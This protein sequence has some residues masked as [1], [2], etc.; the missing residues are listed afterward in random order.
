M[1]ANLKFKG[2][3][4]GLTCIMAFASTTDRALAL[5]AEVAKKCNELLA[6]TYPPLVVGNPAAGRKGTVKERNEHYRK[7]IK[8]GSKI[9]EK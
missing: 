4:F 3:L 7:C 8:N 2:A 9:P 6:I 1:L 5:S